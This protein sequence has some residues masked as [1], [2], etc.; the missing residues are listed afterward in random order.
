MDKKKALD[1]MESIENSK[2]KKKYVKPEISAISLFA[3][4]V[5]EVC[6]KEATIPTEHCN[7]D[8]GGK[9]S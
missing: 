4:Q 8:Y 3:D 6:G 7:F 9:D 1:D 5:L 2:D